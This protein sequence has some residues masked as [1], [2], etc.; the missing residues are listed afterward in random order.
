MT[1]DLE[2]MTDETRL[3]QVLSN[4]L[5]NAITHAFRTITWQQDNIRFQLRYMRL[6]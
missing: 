4:L 3:N 5:S 2:L 1:I 6:L